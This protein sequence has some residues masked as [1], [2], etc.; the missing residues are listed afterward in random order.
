MKNPL[1]I[2]ALV[3]T[4]SWRHKD[5]DFAV[6][7]SSKFG[8]DIIEI[9][10]LNPYNFDADYTRKILEINKI[11]AVTSLGLSDETDI[12]SEDPEIRR[13]G[14]KLLSKALDM[15]YQLGSKYMGGVLYSALK[16]YH[17]PPSKNAFQNSVEIIRDLCHKAEKMEIMIGLEP[18]NRYESNLINTASKAL[19]FIELT[20]SENV[21]V[22]LDSYHMNIEESSYRKSIIQCG[23]KL[24]YF[25]V[26]ENHRGYLG[27]GNID[28]TEI[29]TTMKDIGYQGPITF[30]SFSSSVVEPQL[31][32]TLAVWRNLWDDSNDL[33]KNAK[34]YMDNL[35]KT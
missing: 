10:L 34:S 14:V 29:F 26:G 8:F 1:G 13:N 19:E 4:G 17:A 31:S 18:V 15:T 20:E 21:C 33:A 27:S 24:G 16:K 35:M 7:S 2:H 23:R 32:N 9:P 11:N 6:G 3:W 28:F 25:H 12:T 22:H 5:I 30:E